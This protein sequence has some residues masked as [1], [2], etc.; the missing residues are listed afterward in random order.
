MDRP[1][2]V[3]VSPARYVTLSMA[4]ALTGRTVKSMERKIARGVWLEGREFR[5][6][7]D[8]GICVDMEGLNKWVEGM[9]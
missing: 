7:P 8:R 5:R 6:D 1:I 3:Q 2:I 9:V 4:A